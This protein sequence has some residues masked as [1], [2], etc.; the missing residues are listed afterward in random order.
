MQKRL[1]ENK[2]KSQRNRFTVLNYTRSTNLHDE[3][4]SVE[5]QLTIVDVEKE[6][7]AAAKEE[8]SCSSANDSKDSLESEYVYDIYIAE[9]TPASILDSEP[10]DIN[11]L[12]IL[13]YNDY[14]YSCPR[15]VNDSDDEDDGA[16]SSDSNDENYYRNDYPD[17]DE[18]VYSENESIDERMMRAAV[19][20][21]NIENDLSTDED[22]ENFVYSRNAG[23]VEF[24]DDLDF[25]DVGRYGRSYAIYKKKMLC[26]MEDNDFSS[27]D[28][29]DE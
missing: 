8:A 3:E 5:E 7:Q 25:S 26:E 13:D 20:H 22:E 15:L 27:D 24:E 16:D 11:D 12:S 14:L 1:T 23:G 6:I 19:K 21:F 4:S 17:E 10:F 9:N 28:D 29:D 18:F 2:E